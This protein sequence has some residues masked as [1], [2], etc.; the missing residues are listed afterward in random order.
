MR[1]IYHLHAETEIIETAKYYESRV[2]G[3]G[4]RFLNEFDVAVSLIREAPQRWRVIEADVRRY[5]VPRIEPGNT[6]LLPLGSSN[7]THDNTRS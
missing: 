4:K 2:N 1:V 5:F 6:S 3:L 7:Y